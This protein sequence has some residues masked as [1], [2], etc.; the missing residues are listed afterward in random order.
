MDTIN[1]ARNFATKAHLGQ[2]RKGDPQKP[3]I[4]HPID[5]SLKLKEYGFDDNVIAAGLLHDVVED[6]K[7]EIND[8]EKKFG[9]DVASLVS[10]ATEPDKSLSWEERKEYTISE[11]KTLDLRHKAVICADKISNLED[12]RMISEI[13]GNYDFSAFRRGF[14]KQKWYYTEVYNGLVTDE[15]E[16]LPMFLKLK[17]LIDYIFNDENPNKFIIDNIFNNNIDEYNKLLKFHYRK[18]EIYKLKKVLSKQQ[19][20]V[21]EFTGTPRTGKTTLINNIKDFFKKK[22]FKVEVLEEFTT[23]EK[24]K[25]EIYPLLKDKYKNVINTEIPKYVLKQLKEKI[26]ENPDIIIIDRSL[27]DRLIWVDR[28]VLKAGMSN[29]EYSKFKKTYVPLIKE[30]IDIVLA[31]YTDSITA[32][33]RDYNANLSLEKRTFLNEDNINEYN[34]SLLNMQHLSQEEKIKFYLFDTTNKNQR[35]ISF[36]VIDKILSNMKEKYLKEVQ[37]EY[38]K[39]GETK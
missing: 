10:G 3:M 12:L 1:Q 2:V 11:I 27:F 5:V 9:M 16:N 7:Y 31:T 18:E 15:D 32:L 19:P 25:K 29:E 21:I 28:L 38:T 36:E 26:S 30:N 20:Y 22:G 4:I 6:T 17:E 8:I 35:D 13:K 14:E 39:N 23:S 37:K 33:K 24:Y 34:Q